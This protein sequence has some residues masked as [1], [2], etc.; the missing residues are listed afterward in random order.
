MT[1][2][3]LPEKEK[4]PSVESDFSCLVLT[5]YKLTRNDFHSS[6]ADVVQPLYPQHLVFRFE[7][8]RYALLFGKL[9]YQPRKHCFC[10]LVEVCK[11]IVQL[12]GGQQ[13]CIQTGRVLANVSQ[14]SLSPNANRPALR[15][16]L[17]GNQIVVPDKLIL[18][19]CPFVC[20]VFLHCVV[21]LELYCFSG[22][23][24]E[25]LTVIIGKLFLPAVD[26]FAFLGAQHLLTVG[27]PEGLAANL[28][29]LLTEG[30][31]ALFSI[32]FLFFFGLLMGFRAIGVTKPL[33]CAVRIKLFAA[34]FAD[35][36]RVLM[37]FIRR[38][39]FRLGFGLMGNITLTLPSFLALSSALRSP[40][41]STYH[42]V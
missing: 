16:L 37:T 27:R 32:A 20:D 6:A 5:V 25:L 19:A 22:F 14:V 29:D 35:T 38:P 31:V 17:S 42:S 40:Y 41:L 3:I 18:Q 21:L 36:L 34:L 9:L 24:P 33:P 15:F 7:G 1:S 2:W 13:L 4:P 12:A 28:A 10:L 23:L 26:G 30:V 8:F 11:V 39:A